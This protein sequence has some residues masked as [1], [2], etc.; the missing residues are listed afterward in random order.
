MNRISIEAKTN[1]E[2]RDVI[3]SFLSYLVA[4]E[5]VSSAS[6]TATVYSGTDAS[7]SAVIDGAAAISSPTVTQ[8]ITGGTEGVTYNLVC[9][10][11][12]ST[13]QIVQVGGYLSV[14]PA[15]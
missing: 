9:A 15:A 2:T 1:A 11:T 13:G 4:G 10:A 6:T 8:S 5:T 7:P 12:T 14:V 3:F